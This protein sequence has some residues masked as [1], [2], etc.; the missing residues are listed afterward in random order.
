MVKGRFSLYRGTTNTENLWIPRCE[1]YSSSHR[2]CNLAMDPQCF[3]CEIT[4]KEI[5]LV[6]IVIMGENCSI[7][8]TEHYLQVLQPCSPIFSYDNHFAEII[9][10]ATTDNKLMKISRV[11]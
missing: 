9:R 2:P 10:A 4:C 1:E 8:K 3:V 7:S 5:F 11:F 6:Y